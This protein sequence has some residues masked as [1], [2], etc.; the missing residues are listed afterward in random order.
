MESGVPPATL[1]REQAIGESQGTGLG[2][3]TRGNS[4]MGLAERMEP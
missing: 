3:P 4:E 2:W 1:P